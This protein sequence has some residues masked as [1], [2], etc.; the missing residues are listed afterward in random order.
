MFLL[1]MTVAKVYEMIFEK[2]V[3]EKFEFEF[4]N[5]QVDLEEDTV[6]ETI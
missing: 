3:R 2:E 4:E 6:H 1:L 5:A